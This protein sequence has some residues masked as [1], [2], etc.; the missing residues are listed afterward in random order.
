LAVLLPAG[1]VLLAAAALASTAQAST[2][3]ITT[4]ADELTSQDGLCSLREAVAAV[5]SPGIATDCGPASSISN[6]I[7]LPA[8]Q[9][10][11][12][13][14]PAGADDDLSGDLNVT[15]TAQLAIVGAGESATVIDA[16]GLGDRV[17]SIATA[18]TVTLQKLE[19]T[20]G[21][22]LDGTAGAVGGGNGSTAG[23][24]GAG[25]GIYNAGTLSLIGVGVLGNT[26][27][28]GGGG[29][30]GGVCQVCG[31]TRGG[32]GASGG[33]GGG[34]Y[35]AGALR[36]T[37]SAILN[38]NSGGGGGGGRG[39]GNGRPFYPTGP[40]GN[41]GAGGAGGGIYSAGSAATLTV[42]NSTIDGNRGG[43]GGAGGGSPFGNGGAAAGGG[44]G[45]G[46]ASQGRMLVVLRSTIADNTAGSGGG[47]GGGFRFGG[48]GASG[49]S[50]GGI[51]AVGGSLDVINS[52]LAGNHAGYGG[53]GGSAAGG[54]SKAGNGGGGGNGG[55]IA[56]AGVAS[57]SVVRNATI[58]NNGVGAGGPGGAGVSSA[59]PGSG[60]LPGN[61][62]GFADSTALT[63][64]NTIVASNKAKGAANCSPSSGVADGGHDL[65][66]GDGSC[67]GARG[68]PALK[69]LSDYG[70]PT[71][72]MAL[73]PGSAAIDQVPAT[74]AG[75]PATD[76]RGVQRPQGSACDIGAFEFATPQITI[77]APGTATATR[78][79]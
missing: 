3:M 24:T 29:G 59:T 53:G 41:G 22:A 7:R 31:P 12:S 69:A 73:A 10:V 76:Q 64:Q 34:I 36:V 74:G 49:S 56:A 18:A 51:S 13:I 70:G 33:N 6:M 28:A 5:N 75:C 1:L 78:W 17:L 8:G 38:N 27:G 43:D 67:P 47:G 30:F 55:A 71:Q 20:G 65:K 72:T 63:L 15:G 77:T 45:G 46:I 68:N 50:G 52:T 4:T 61:G 11:L 16:T 58:A 40:G 66:Y 44:G 39:G 54:A 48:D 14:A 37:G 57:A 62:G 21:H 23:S 25:G 26:A 19:I 35:N 32:N 9:Y 79:A 60:G 2:L 42:T